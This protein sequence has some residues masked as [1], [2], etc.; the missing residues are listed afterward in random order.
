M[1]E[2][3]QELINH[4]WCRLK[5]I[6]TFKQSYPSQF[7]HQ[8]NGKVI[9]RRRGEGRE[10]RL[11]KH[12]TTQKGLKDRT[13]STGEDNMKENGK[14]TTRPVF[15]QQL[16]TSQETAHL[17]LIHH[18]QERLKEKKKKLAQQV[19]SALL[20]WSNQNRGAIKNSFYQASEPS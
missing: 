13:G 18:H 15:H 2:A 8:S 20:S 5:T 3:G 6:T 1:W 14:K 4:H 19:V 7:F 11:L 17:P 10:S 16:P 12:L 9:W